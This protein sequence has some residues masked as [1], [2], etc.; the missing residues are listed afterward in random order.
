MSITWETFAHVVD[1]LFPD[2]FLKNQNWAYLWTNNLKFYA[3]C[4]YEISSRRLS[5]CIE[6]KL[7]TTC[8]YLISYKAFLKKQRGL[9]LVSLTHFLYDFWRKMFLLL[10]SI[11]WVNFIVRL[12]LFLQILGYM[13]I[14]IVNQVVTA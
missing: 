11:T 8:I 10:Y 6:T 14:V 13:F 9:V 3:V 1:K 7:Q 12:P 5:K 2:P 4:F